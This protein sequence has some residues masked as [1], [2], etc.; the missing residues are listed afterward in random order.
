M[1]TIGTIPKTDRKWHVVNI[2]DVP[3]LLEFI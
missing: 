1:Y 2:E 3:Q